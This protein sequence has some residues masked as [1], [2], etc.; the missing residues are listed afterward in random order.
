MSWIR[1]MERDAVAV[2]FPTWEWQDDDIVTV[3]QAHD[4]GYNYSEYTN[5]PASFRISVDVRRA[6]ATLYE[7]KWNAQRSRG[8]EFRD[9]EAEQFW[10]D[11]MRQGSKR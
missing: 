6:D 5:A 8:I 9:E 1:E 4:P 10:L 2:A 3:S 11:L 7:D